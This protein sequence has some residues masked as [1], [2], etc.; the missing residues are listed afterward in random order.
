METLL[1][2]ALSFSRDCALVLFI[3][4]TTKGDAKS[5]CIPFTDKEVH[6]YLKN[7]VF[8]LAWDERE[9]SKKFNKCGMFSDLIKDQTVRHNKKNHFQGGINNIRPETSD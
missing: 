7:A 8:E 4:I 1:R 3:C 9:M 2:I 5:L 6:L